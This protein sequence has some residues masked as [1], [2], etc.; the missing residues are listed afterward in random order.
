M[1]SWKKMFLLG[2]LLCHATCS[3]RSANVREGTAQVDVPLNS[4]VN[5]DVSSVDVRAPMAVDVNAGRR[6]DLPGGRAISVQQGQAVIQ[7]RHG[8]M[9]AENSRL[10]RAPDENGNCPSEGFIEILTNERGFDLHQQTCG[11]W[12]FIDEMLTFAPNAD[13][14]YLLIRFTLRYIDRRSP[15]EDTLRVLTPDD[16][17]TV[18]IEDV[19]LDRLYRLL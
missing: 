1:A 16:F 18:R 7:D 13:D 12:Y 9:L 4:S 14:Q 19:E 15:D 6:I 3:S 5:E 11:G 2:T 8:R 17:G 10:I